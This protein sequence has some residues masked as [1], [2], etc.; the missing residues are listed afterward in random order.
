MFFFVFSIDPFL[1]STENRLIYKN[2]TLDYHCINIDYEVRG[3]FWGINALACPH[4]RKDVT[5]RDS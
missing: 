3:V 5:Q 4:A 2:K 1:S